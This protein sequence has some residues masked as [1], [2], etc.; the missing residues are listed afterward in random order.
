VDED[1][2]SPPCVRRQAGRSLVRHAVLDAELVTQ[3]F[4]PR[5]RKSDAPPLPTHTERTRRRARAAGRTASL[6]LKSHMSTTTRPK[7]GAKLTIMFHGSHESTTQCASRCAGKRGTSSSSSPWNDLAHSARSGSSARACAPAREKRRARRVR[8]QHKPKCHA[9]TQSR[10]VAP[11]SKRART[12]PRPVNTHDWV[13]S[14]GRT[15]AATQGGTGRVNNSPCSASAC[16][17]RA[18]SRNV[19]AL[20]RDQ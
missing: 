20:R 5:T 16:A 1:T 7:Y 6:V 9:R 13:R 3:H 12:A 11:H 8:N 18:T 14:S 4:L 10:P 17:A 19:H 2:L 15:L